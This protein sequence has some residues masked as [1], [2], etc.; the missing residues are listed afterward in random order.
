MSDTLSLVVVDSGL[1]GLS[2]VADLAKK[3]AIKSPKPIANLTFYNAWPSLEIPYN[4]MPSQEIKAKVFSDALYGTDAFDP[5]K[6]LIACNTLSVLLEQTDY[7]KNSNT[8]V[9]GIIN[10]GVQSIL[11]KL[12]NDPNS[13][14]IIV[15]TPTTIEADS[16][17]EGLLKAGIEEHRIITQS[18]GRLAEKIEQNPESNEVNK[19]IDHFTEEAKQ[20]ASITQETS[21]YAALCCTHYGYSDKG[22]Q[23]ALNASF[24]RHVEIINPN[25]AMSE[26]SIPHSEHSVSDVTLNIKVVSRVA[27]EQD[28]ID[29]IGRIIKEVS[30]ETEQALLQYELNDDLFAFDLTL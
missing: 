15:A 7:I 18:Y 10:F 3:L 13:I 9:L 29:A 14:V 27:I 12:K 17:R 24:S 2:V 19:I 26:G 4:A 16:H 22:F 28:K 5:N 30:P 20:K 8:D 11:D 25:R 23:R 6:V 1:G 21:V